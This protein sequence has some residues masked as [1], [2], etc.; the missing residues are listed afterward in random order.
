M[1]CRRCDEHI[2]RAGVHSGDSACSLPPYSL[3][4]KTVDELKQQTK[5]LAKALNVVGLMNVQ[6]AVRNG[7]IYVLEVNPRASRTAPF[8]SK[9]TGL[10][11][12]KIAAKAMAGI[13][14]QAQGVTAVP[15]PDYFSVKEA[16]FPFNKFPNVDVLLG[17]EMKSTGETMGIGKDFPPLFCCRKMP[18]IRRHARAQCYLAFAMKIGGIGNRQN[19]CRTRICPGGDQRHGGIFQRQRRAE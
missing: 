17:P 16:V 10:P 4:A 12:A 3:P 18:L 11:I 9:A 1:H 15:V 19:I 5:I 2:E 14:L 13:S 6:F 7:D 8:V